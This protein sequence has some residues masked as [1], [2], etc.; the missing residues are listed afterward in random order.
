MKNH[1][2]CKNRAGGFCFMDLLADLLFEQQIGG[3]A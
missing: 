1:R 3:Y 2:L